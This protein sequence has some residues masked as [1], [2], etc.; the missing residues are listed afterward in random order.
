MNKMLSKWPVWFK[1]TNVIFKQIS[2]E[3]NVRSCIE[4]LRDL[5]HVAL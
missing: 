3:D 5:M 1:V 4:E 2:A